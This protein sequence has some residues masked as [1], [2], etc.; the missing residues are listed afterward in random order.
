[1][2]TDKTGKF[3]YMAILVLYYQCPCCTH[4]W[5]DWQHSYCPNCE[6]KINYPS[7]SVK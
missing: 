5:K 2:G 3:N 1:M 7:I 6:V 4:K